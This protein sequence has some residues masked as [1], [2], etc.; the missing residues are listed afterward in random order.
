MIQ[1]RHNFS[2]TRVGNSVLKDETLKASDKAVYAVLSMYADNSTSQCYP[3][4]ETVIRKAG[5]SDKTLRSSIKKLSDKGY[6]EV[7][8][9]KRNKPNLYVLLNK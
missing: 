4:R 2:H 7:R 9:Q 1:D 3:K 5:V 6:I 8:R